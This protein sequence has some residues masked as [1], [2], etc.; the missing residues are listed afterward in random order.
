MG[1]NTQKEA[2]LLLQHL[3]LSLFVLKML[4]PSLVFKV[5]TLF[6]YVS[7]VLALPWQPHFSLPALVEWDQQMCT[8]ISVP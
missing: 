7:F 1:K 6:I 4:Q 2:M 5:F 3:Q 8:E